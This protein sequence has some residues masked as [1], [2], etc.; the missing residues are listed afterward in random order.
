M[1]PSSSRSWT[2]SLL[3]L[4]FAVLAISAALQLAA[5]L[6]LAALPILLPAAGFVLLGLLAWRAYSR[7]GTW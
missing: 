4:A 6:L 5:E 1:S 3:G 2:A 7:R